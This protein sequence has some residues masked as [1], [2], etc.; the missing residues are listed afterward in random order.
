MYAA[1]RIR[2]GQAVAIKEFLPTVIDCRQSGEH[3]RIRDRDQYNRF[4]EGLQS[5][6]READLVSRLSHPQIIAI[7]DVFEANGTAYFAMPLERGMS[8]AGIIK[9]TPDGIPDADILNIFRQATSGVGALHQSGLLHLDIKPS[10]LWVRPDGTVVVLDLGTSQWEDHEGRLTNL[11]RT[12]GFAA[13]EQH[14]GRRGGR[15]S[16]RTD[17]YG[18]AASI[19]MA[20]EGTPPDTAVDRLSHRRADGSERNPIRQTRM[21]QRCPDILDI[22][23]CGMRLEPDL[24]FQSMS[25]MADAL[26]DAARPMHLSRTNLTDDLR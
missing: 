1:R 12:P 21:G 22:V 25:D 18:M 7:W 14:G 20:I 10:N 17:V 26:A 13:P 23:D 16:P 5:F 11:A 9:G 8:L 6:F 19:Y 24:R 3:I 2:D 4:Q 15:L